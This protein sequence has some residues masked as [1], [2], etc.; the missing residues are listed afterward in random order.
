VY[1]EDD[2]EDDLPGSARISRSNTRGTPFTYNNCATVTT[3]PRGSSMEEAMRRSMASGQYADLLR[4][5]NSSR[6]SDCDCDTGAGVSRSGH[7]GVGDA[8]GLG[9]IEAS[10][11]EAEAEAEAT[12]LSG[13][14][15]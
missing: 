13:N 15:M 4:T 7:A 3:R 10:S 9:E 14:G 11:A 1:S 12:R 6:G 2:C 5:A 8:E